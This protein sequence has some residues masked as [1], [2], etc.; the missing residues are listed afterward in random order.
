MALTELPK[1]TEPVVSALPLPGVTVMSL[2][3]VAVL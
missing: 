1:V 3:W 2:D